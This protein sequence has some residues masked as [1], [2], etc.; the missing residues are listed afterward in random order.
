MSEIKIESK[1]KIN[2]KLLIGAAVFIAV[3]LVA[4]FVVFAPKTADAKKIQ[5][6]LSLGEKYL[7]ELEYEQAIAAYLAVIKIDPKNVDAYL[8]LADVYMALGEYDKAI[9]VLEDAL[10]Y[11]S[12]DAAV[13]IE[14]KLVEVRMEKALAE[15]TPTNTPIP[16]ATSTLTPELSSTETTTLNPSSIDLIA[17]AEIGDVVKFGRF[18]ENAAM[19]DPEKSLMLELE[20]VIDDE[21]K[22]NMFDSIAKDIE[23]YV[24]D[25]KEDKVLLFSK[26]V[27]DTKPYHKEYTEVTWAQSSIR[28]WLNSTFYN[29]AFNDTEKNYICKTKI[30]NNDTNFDFLQYGSVG[31]E[32]TI[33]NVFLLSIEEAK[34]YF[35]YTYDDTSMNGFEEYENSEL[36]KRLIGVVTNYAIFNGSMNYGIDGSEEC[37]TMWYLRSL[38]YGN[39]FSAYVESNGY[40]DT[41]GYFSI[42][43]PN[44]IRPAIWVD[45][46]GDSNDNDILD[47]TD[48][49]EDSEERI[50]HSLKANPENLLS[51][52]ELNFLGHSIVDLNID[53]VQRLLEENNYDVSSNLDWEDSSETDHIWLGGYPN[54]I[55]NEAA[56]IADI[57]AIQYF[58]ENYA[59]SWGY[60]QYTFDNDVKSPVGVRNIQMHDTFGEVVEKIGFS[61]SYEVEAD[62]EYFFSEYCD[63]EMMDNDYEY[64]DAFDIMATY[65]RNERLAGLVIYSGSMGWSDG[66]DYHSFSLRLSDE[67]FEEKNG[68]RSYNLELEFEQDENTNGKFILTGYSMHVN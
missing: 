14:E 3:A 25:R 57:S 2:K 67:L 37:S 41:Q 5:E 18:L 58:T 55:R 54:Y 48:G 8:G 23:W 44:G 59:R 63:F 60:T 29:V 50:F 46:M 52:D 7:S 26:Y 12:R 53:T 47:L 1:N 56:G 49:I 21:N 42:D 51:F 9:D 24:L 17:S 36:D 33:D 6:Q 32:N 61:N 65:R 68:N 30:L 40:I 19:I 43:T 39:L 28:E 16:T 11:I 4:I 31:G 64:W 35:N 34:K 22:R 10:E 27:L 20:D 13:I 66:G 38:G 15:I 62:I 45:I